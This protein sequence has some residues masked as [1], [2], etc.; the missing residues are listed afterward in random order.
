MVI[1]QPKTSLSYI[2]RAIEHVDVP[3]YKYPISIY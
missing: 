3:Y 1:E 2:G